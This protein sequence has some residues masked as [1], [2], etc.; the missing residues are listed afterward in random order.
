MDADLLAEQLWAVN[1]PVLDDKGLPV[2]PTDAVKAY[3][4]GFIAM[5]ETAIV[6]HLPGTAVGS[7]PP[8]GDLTSGAAEGG[9]MTLMASPVMAQKASAGNPVVAAQMVIESAAIASYLIASGLV[10]FL[11]GSITGQSTET[12]APAPG[13]LV[14]GE[15]MVGKISGLDG[16][17]LANLAVPPFTGPGKIPH[18]TA[19][20]GHLMT[21]GEVTYAANTVL[22]T[23]TGGA[24]TVGAA[25]GGLVS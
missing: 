23:M 12:P 21:L 25:A 6:A 13:P 18:Y 3:A 24:L 5:L 11:P 10:S 8:G 4:A 14:N 19:L 2:P 15:G 20:V 22:G 1:G 7:A 9:K 17:T 16:A